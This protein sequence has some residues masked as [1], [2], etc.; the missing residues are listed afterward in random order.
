VDFK[1]KSLELE[2]RR[3]KLS[4]WVREHPGSLARLVLWCIWIV[5]SWV[6]RIQRDRNGF[7]L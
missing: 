4:I 3:Y 2:G 6:H 7:G 5:L 1:V